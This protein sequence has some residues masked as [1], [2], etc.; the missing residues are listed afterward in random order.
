MTQ[1]IRSTDATKVLPLLLVNKGF[2][3]VELMIAVA[4]LGIIAAIAAPMYRGYISNA[5][6]SAA[7]AVVDQMPVLVETYRA[8]NGIMCP[9]PP[10][11]TYTYTE[12]DDG[13]VNTDTI[14]PVYPGFKAKSV[15]QTSASL[16]H[17]TLDFSTI[18]APCTTLPCAVITAHPQAGRGAPAGDIPNPPKGFQ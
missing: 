10:Y 17:Y 8:D 18:V 12:N 9:G 16:Y 14:T 13:T 4:I 2:T 11:L 1:Q 5:K 3:F 7:K 6:Q 15:T